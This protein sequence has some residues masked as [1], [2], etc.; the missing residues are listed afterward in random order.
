M[1][2]C[3]P[4][5]DSDRTV[6]KDYFDHRC[7]AHVTLGSPRS[8]IRARD[9]I[10]RH[11]RDLSERPVSRLWSSDRCFSRILILGSYKILLR[12]K[13]AGVRQSPG[14]RRQR[15]LDHSANNQALHSTI[16][17][18]MVN[19]QALTTWLEQIRLIGSAHQIR[20][21]WRGGLRCS[22]SCSL[23]MDAARS[24]PRVCILRLWQRAGGLLPALAY[25]RRK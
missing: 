4:L 21:S 5:T 16:F 3:V 18:K 13:T 22:L 19:H 15:R 24:M 17:F 23:E 20:L 8:V 10:M 12:R 25:V 7:L 11:F 14:H 6:T 1:L 9:L 2:S